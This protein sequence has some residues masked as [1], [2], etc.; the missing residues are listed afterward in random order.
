[1]LLLLPTREFRHASPRSAP[2]RSV[3]HSD[4]VRALAWNGGSN[5]VT[6]GWD[7]ALRVVRVQSVSSESVQK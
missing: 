6:G 4:Y 1:M 5:L 3:L 2:D 7:E